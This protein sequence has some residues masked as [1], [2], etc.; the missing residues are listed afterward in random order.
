MKNRIDIEEVESIIKAE[1]RINKI[2]PRK[3]RIFK[4]G[5]EVEISKEVRKE[6]EF[7]GLTTIDF[8]TSGYY[9]RKF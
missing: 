1:Q 5:K 7:T 8:I 2:S 3:A 6:F 4:D 9:L